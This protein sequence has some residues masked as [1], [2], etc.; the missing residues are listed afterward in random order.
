MLRLEISDLLANS[1]D[2][3]AY[4]VIVNGTAQF[5]NTPF[6]PKTQPPP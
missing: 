1:S 3:A 4:S 2:V 6:V 5:N